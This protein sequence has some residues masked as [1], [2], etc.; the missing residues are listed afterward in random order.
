MGEGPTF[1][2]AEL[3][4]SVA[5]GIDFNFDEFCGWTSLTSAVASE[6]VTSASVP[7]SSFRV[8]A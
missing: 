2:S 8:A 7:S 4:A 6:S 1:E 3:G 5:C